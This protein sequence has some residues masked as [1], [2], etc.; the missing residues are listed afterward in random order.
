MVHGVRFTPYGEGWDPIA[1]DIKTPDSFCQENTITSAN[2]PERSTLRL[3]NSR[4]L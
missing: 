3:K 2:N 1:N 4:C